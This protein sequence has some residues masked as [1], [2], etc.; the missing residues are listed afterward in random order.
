[1]PKSKSLV[2][3]ARV[4]GTRSRV[5]SAESLALSAVVAARLM[6]RLM[7]YPTICVRARVKSKCEAPWV[8]NSLTVPVA[9]AQGGSAIPNSSIEVLSNGVFIT[10]KFILTRVS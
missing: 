7:L 9:E 4:R 5:L 6:S 10:E 2:V 3:I 1:M 8:N